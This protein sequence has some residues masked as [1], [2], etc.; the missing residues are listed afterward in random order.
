MVRKVVIAVLTIIAVYVTGLWIDSYVRP[1]RHWLGEIMRQ[2]SMHSWDH[3]EIR[4]GMLI[5]KNGQRRITA[6]IESRFT[7]TAGEKPNRLQPFSVP[8]LSL[9]NVGAAIDAPRPHHMENTYFLSSPAWLILASLWTFP[10]YCFN[11]VREKSAG[12]G[13][14]D[15]PGISSMRWTSSAASV[16]VRADVT[17][18]VSV[19]TA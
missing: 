3:W 16:G 1:S 11:H 18:R 19:T 10:G 14:S 17:R 5:F 13:R 9:E 15:S 6:V 2:F 12:T 8:G 4:G 7:L